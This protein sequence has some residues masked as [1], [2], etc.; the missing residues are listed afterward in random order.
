MSQ[1]LRS[2]RRSNDVEQTTGE[3]GECT[4]HDSFL[5]ATRMF[6]RLW[7]LVIYGNY[8]TLSILC[9]CVCVCARKIFMCRFSTLN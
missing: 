8:I 6:A 7:C 1:L 3:M 5:Y 9:V 4:P 2:E